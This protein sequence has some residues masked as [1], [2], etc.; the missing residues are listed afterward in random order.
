V[1]LGIY[2]IVRVAG[3]KRRSEDARRANR[4]V[5]HCAKSRNPLKNLASEK[6]VFLLLL[7]E[8]VKF[9]KAQGTCGGPSPYGLVPY[10]LAA[11]REKS[12]SLSRIY[13][14]QVLNIL[15]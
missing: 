10:G 13:P 4:D 9:E 5:I 3:S 7:L 14:Q 1:K 2:A 6:L 11:G 12:A 15:I 8:R